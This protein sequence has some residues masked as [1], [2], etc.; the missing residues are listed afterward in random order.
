[1]FGGGLSLSLL[2][3]VYLLLLQVVTQSGFLLG[4]QPHYTTTE[5]F[6]TFLLLLVFIFFFCF[7][8]NG[9]ARDLETGVCESWLHITPS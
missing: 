1:M 6:I 7:F 2:P 8:F 9:P 5:I 4:I 3:A